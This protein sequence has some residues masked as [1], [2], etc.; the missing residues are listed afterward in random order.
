M[1]NMLNQDSNVQVP[2]GV[3]L[4]DAVDDVLQRYRLNSFS[5]VNWVGIAFTKAFCG[6]MADL[7]SC[8][9]RA[10]RESGHVD[11]RKIAEEDDIQAMIDM[12]EVSL[13][14]FSETIVNMT[15]PFTSEPSDPALRAL[16]EQ[17]GKRLAELE[18]L[19]D[20]KIFDT[21]ISYGYLDGYVFAIVRERTS[22]ILIVLTE[23]S[24]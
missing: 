14:D 6:T 22:E 11:G 18:E 3:S 17:G 4:K 20:S 2:H 21:G 15:W 1:I 16:R 9:E 5:D 19:R 23:G 7:E 13:A 24:D 8:A 12:E 10:V